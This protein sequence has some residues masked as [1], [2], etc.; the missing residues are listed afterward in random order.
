MMRRSLLVTVL[1]AGTLVA[2]AAARQ[3][4][5]FAL[6]ETTIS[7][8]H[9]AMREGRLTCRALVDQYLRRIDAYDKNGPALNAIVLTNPRVLAQADAL[10][11]RSRAGRPARAAALRADDREGQLR[12]HRPAERERLA[13]ARRLRLDRRT[14]SR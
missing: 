3:T 13:G 14:P 7:A 1:A 4:V 8:V 12:D 9:A 11:A 2:T 5:P 6:E 10:D